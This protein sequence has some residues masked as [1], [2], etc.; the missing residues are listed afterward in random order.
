MFFTSTPA[1]APVCIT[2]VP[3]SR[4]LW[5]SEKENVHAKQSEQISQGKTNF[6]QWRHLAFVID[7][8]W[9]QARRLF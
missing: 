1:A 3:R 7:A 6:S 2:K 9:V 8:P 5:I 4:D